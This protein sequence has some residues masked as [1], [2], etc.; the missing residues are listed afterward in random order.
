[1]DEFQC[2]WCNRCFYSKDGHFCFLVGKPDNKYS[3]TFIDELEK[4]AERLEA[5]T[6]N[7]DC[8]SDGFGYSNPKTQAHDTQLNSSLHSGSNFLTKNIFQG[9]QVTYSPA[10]SLSTQC[11]G[12]N[13]D[14]SRSD[15]QI[16]SQKSIFETAEES[17]K[18]SL[19]EQ[20]EASQGDI[21][22]SD[23]NNS[24]PSENRS[25]QKESGWCNLRP[26]Q[27]KKHKNTGFGT[28]A[29]TSRRKENR[30]TQFN[31][32]KKRSYLDLISASPTCIQRDGNK[33]EAQE[34]KDY[35][36]IKS[37]SAK[38]TQVDDCSTNEIFTN[39]VAVGS[40]AVSEMVS[41][42]GP[43]GIHTQSHRTGKEKRFV[44]DVCGK[45]FSTEG[46]IGTHYRIHT[47]EKPFVCDICGKGFSQ[48]VHFDCH[49]R[50]HT[51][52]KP[53]VC[54]MRGKEFTTKGNLR[55]H[56]RIHTGEKP[57]VCDICGKGFTQ[58]GNF[59][60]HC[61]THMGEKLLVSDVRGKGISDK[62]NLTEHVPTHEGGKR[63]KCGVCGETF[64]SN[65]YRNR[66]HKEKHQ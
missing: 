60:T 61:K 21:C 42:A 45:D 41:V 52:E 3:E 51:G 33:A 34:T 40:D 1:M 9:E 48:K 17:P 63:Y 38:V 7:Q 46:K 39:S 58:K 65:D 20:D 47:G 28:D 49:Y 54:D 56:Y 27:Q 35:S 57:F 66:H 36:K 59:G 16:S 53:F 26:V 43:S 44:C 18:N 32:G 64:S 8:T 62:R 22:L 31:L 14:V 50:T 6:R 5:A 4:L 15:S 12:S 55:I 10:T 24:N 23:D 29:R 2:S 13:L 11:H 37:I 30:S 25:S 19:F